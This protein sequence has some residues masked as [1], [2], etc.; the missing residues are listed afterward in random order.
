MK[1]NYQGM[2]KRFGIKILV[3]AGMSLGLLIPLFMVGSLIYDRENTRD[4]VVNEVG[5]S[6]SDVSREGVW[7]SRLNDLTNDYDDGAGS[8]C[9]AGSQIVKGPVARM[10]VVSRNATDTVP[11]K[12][13]VQV[14][15]PLILNYNVNAATEELHRSIYN[16]VVY[17]SAI[18]MTGKMRV[19][20]NS[21]GDHR[22]VFDI[23]VRDFK[24][25]SSYPTG[26]IGGKKVEFRRS[27]DVLT[28][29]TLTFE[30][31][32]KGDEIDFSIEMNL[33]GSHGL[34][35]RPCGEE[36]SLS[37][38]SCYPHPSFQGAFLPETREITDE[39]FSATWKV[40]SMNM[41]SGRHEA[42][43][44]VFV[45]PA[46]PYHQTARS[47]KY[48]LLI[49]VLVF[50]ASLVA[51]LLS[52]K[53][54]SYLQYVVIGLSL[55]LFYALLL[56]ISEIIPFGFAYLIAAA[57]TI[58]ALALYFRA[59]IGNKGAYILGGF[60]VL[61]YGANY[62]LLQMETYALLAGTLVLFAVLSAVMYLTANIK[63][64]KPK[65]SAIEEYESDI[66]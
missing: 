65:K 30:G 56:S 55:V 4:K 60:L 58:S 43:G 64:E 8:V 61:M 48:G 40:L 31:M 6:Y 62:M 28:T 66:E 26:T 15:E 19:P 9:Q 32:K 12:E 33:K 46:N 36:T 49:I 57:M 14:I 20:A 35:F 39:G 27:G 59:I 13:S 47:I 25:L 16:V 11:V 41:D 52:R 5:R 42:I 7:E 17:N 1:L 34:S 63:I 3:I 21:L 18:E 2:P 23:N 53:E 51:E 37:M 10:T 45:D 54:I 38:K 22:F 24:G 29:D 44:V 50:A